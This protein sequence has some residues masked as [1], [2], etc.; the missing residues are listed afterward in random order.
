MKMI[1]VL[2]IILVAVSYYLFSNQF[3]LF[4]AEIRDHTVS[5][6]KRLLCFLL[7]YIW[8][9]IASSLE[10]PLVANWLVFLIILGLE[11]HLALSFD[12]LSSYT[13]SLFCTICGLAVNI[14]FRSLFAILLNLPLSVFDNT[15]TSVKKYPILLGFLLMGLLFLF[16][17]RWQLSKKIR[18]M[19]EN[20]EGLRF[21]FCIECCLYLFL[22]IQLLAYVQTA[23]N[24]GSKV[25]G[26]KASL[27]SLIVLIITN[28]YT[29]RVATLHLYMD[30]KHDQHNRLIEEKKD[31]DA[32]WKLAYTDMLTGSSNRQLLDKRLQEYAN[33]GGTITLAFIDLNGLKIVNDQYGHLEGDAYLSQVS[34]ILKD[35]LKDCHADLFRYGGDEFIAISNSMS[36]EEL[37][38]LLCRVNEQLSLDDNH[39][40]RKSVSYGVIHGSCS[41][42]ARLI[43]DADERMYQHKMKYYEQTARS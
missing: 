38:N 25:W 30:K 8:F 36:E 28:I 21:Y 7:V 34:G 3:F 40:Y 39:E 29:L 24:M 33:Y 5:L 42:Y 22:I 13:L 17:R 32:L 6:G 35:L 12:Y 27:F 18:T 10:L 16:F 41:D 11:V 26:V 9:V 43:Q 31:I 15:T 4:A 1:F 19:I 2:D 37:E 23:N 14:F 20:R